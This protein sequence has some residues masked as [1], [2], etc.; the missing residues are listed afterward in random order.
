MK[1]ENINSTTTLHNGVK[2]PRFG[3]G[4]YKVEDGKEVITTVKTAI[5]NGYRSIDT[6]AIYKNEEGVGI[7]IKE[8]IEEG[9]VSRDELFITSK[10]WNDD[11]GYEATLKA[12][13]ESLRKLNL[14]FIDL[15]LIHW[16]VRGKFKDGWKALETLY[17]QER[18]RAIGVCNFHVH[19]LED[20][21]TEATILPMVDQVEFHPRLAQLKLQ[22]FCR[23]YNIQLEAW[24]PLMQG[25][26]LDNKVLQ[27]ISNKHNKTVAQIILRWELQTGVI[28]IPKSVKE[29]R[30][31]E[32]ADI[33]DFELST[34]DME[35]INQLNVDLRVGTNPDSFDNR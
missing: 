21:F 12:Y 4:V 17:K 28:I 14:D 7:A 19:H 35:I 6:A 29:H 5:K 11:L 15:Y 25:H 10:V 23:K 18:V 8:C 20:L 3:L 30:I 34:K 22:D 9:I 26:L 13:D 1:I 31:I 33:F 16:P 27:I 24:A 32:N 2:M